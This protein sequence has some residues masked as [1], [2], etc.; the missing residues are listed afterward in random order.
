MVTPS[1]PEFKQTSLPTGGAPFPMTSVTY[2]LIGRAPNSD[3]PIVVALDRYPFT[4]GRNSD[5]A[6]VLTECTV[7]S[8]HVE[9]VPTEAGVSVTDLNSTNG[10]FLN[11][12]RVMET[13]PLSDGDI[14]QFG[15]VVFRV[16]SKSAPAYAITDARDVTDEA[17]SLV[18]FEKVLNSRALSPHLQPIVTLQS[19]STFGFEVLARSELHGLRSAGELFQAAARLNAEIALSRK[20]RIAGLAVAK[21]I[22]N[23][24]PLFVNIHPEEVNDPELA[25][26]LRDLRSQWPDRKLVVEIHESTVTNSDWLK[27]LKAALRELKMELAFDDFG[28]GQ[29]RLKELIEVRPN[30]LKFDRSMFDRIEDSTQRRMI[31]TLVE[32]TLELDIVPLAEGVE[33]EEQHAFCRDIGFLIGQGY[34]YGRPMAAVELARELNNTIA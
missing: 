4:I 2:S 1:P 21:A 27:D 9:I 33:T 8:S 29:S 13:T 30:Y 20:S 15:A 6:F 22:P 34:L 17:L 11:G 26:S 16:S 25:D 3:S 14:L 23:C 18:Q 31:E 5:N 7:S 10:T 24:F 32:M 12:D 28:S 19:G